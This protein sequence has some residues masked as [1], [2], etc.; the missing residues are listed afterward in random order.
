[1]G[2]KNDEK[3]NDRILLAVGHDEER[4]TDNWGE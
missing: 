1:V 3:Y 4:K 2:K